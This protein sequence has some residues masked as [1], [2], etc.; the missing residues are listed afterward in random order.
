M[1]FSPFIEPWPP[2]CEPCPL[3]RAR[4]QRH[5]NLP[6]GQSQVDG[7]TVRESNAVHLRGRAGVEES[8]LP[9]SLGESLMYDVLSPTVSSGGSVIKI[10]S[11]VKSS[12]SFFFFRRSYVL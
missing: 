8:G 9:I 11:S 4:L 2:L 3:A 12:E 6:L 10:V 7:R 1:I 5:W